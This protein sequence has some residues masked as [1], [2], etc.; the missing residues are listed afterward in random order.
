MGQIPVEY[1]PPKEFRPHRVYT[2]PEFA[3]LPQ[4]FNSTEE[5]LDKTVAAG[6]GNRAALYF[7]D[8]Q[9]P[10]K[11]LLDQVNRFGSALT[12]LGIEEADRVVLRLPNIPPAIVANFAVLKIG[13]VIVP[14]SVL[15]SRAEIVHICNSTEAKAVIV[16]APLLEEFEQARPLLHTV[17][18]VIVV[19]GAQEEI[20]R[21]GYLSYQALLDGGDPTCD[22]VRR[23]RL[24]VSVLLFTSGTTGPPKG[25]VH[26][27]EEALI[28]P[29]SF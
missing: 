19:G 1:L 12:R 25:T 4:R 11:A 5:L 8:K 3:H 2:L 24:D 28:V 14:T 26:F 6:N 18:H 27:M 17:R 23:D 7:E 9:I 10:Y 16:A 20:E 29:D 22:P 21:K 15:F 13:A